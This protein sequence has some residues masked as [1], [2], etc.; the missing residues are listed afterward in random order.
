MNVFGY[1][2]S[3][4]NSLPRAF[5]GGIIL[6]IIMTIPVMLIAAFISTFLHIKLISFIIFNLWISFYFFVFCIGN[7]R[8]AG[9]YLYSRI[10]SKRIWGFLARLLILLWAGRALYW[11]ASGGARFFADRVTGPLNF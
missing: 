8:S 7:W 4:S 11:L 2:I 9:P 5:W 10:I 6:G 1:L 3:G